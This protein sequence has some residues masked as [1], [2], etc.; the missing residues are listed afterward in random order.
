MTT[1][2]LMDHYTEGLGRLKKLV[3]ARDQ[4][5]DTLRG[6]ASVSFSTVHH[7]CDIDP[8]K[9]RAGLDQII[10]LERQIRRVV[11]DVNI[12]ADASHKK[13]VYLVPRTGVSSEIPTTPLRGP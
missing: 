5:L 3:L 13:R 6:E 4:L 9:L 1:M 12:Y 11:Q 10:E 7:I 8:S 2:D